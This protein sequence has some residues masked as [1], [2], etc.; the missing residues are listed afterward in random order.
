MERT[1][2]I[3]GLD[4][5]REKS[6]ARPLF[7]DSEILRINLDRVG[8]S[9][10]VELLLPAKAEPGELH[11]RVDLRFEDVEGLQLANFNHQNVVFSM[12]V[13]A[14]HEERSNT[15]NTEERL[16]VRIDS[17]FGV[18][19]GFTCASGK[20]VRFDSTDSRTG[21]PPKGRSLND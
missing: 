6:G 7:H 17:V 1:L 15:G 18:E 21:M 19:F 10:T 11:Y 9:I 8:P 14:V 4:A 5:V 3:A 2:Q 13:D 12:T 20:V 16:R